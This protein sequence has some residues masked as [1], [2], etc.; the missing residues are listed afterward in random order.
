M[1]SWSGTTSLKEQF[2][3]LY[4]IRP[5]WNETIMDILNSWKNLTKTLEHARQ[6]A[7]AISVYKV[8]NNLFETKEI[9]LFL[10]FMIVLKR[11]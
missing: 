1:S 6:N 5:Q 9:L 7:G 11:I 10:V 3:S 4:H 2:F 8:L